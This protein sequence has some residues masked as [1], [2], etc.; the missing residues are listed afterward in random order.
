MQIS[1]KATAIL[2]HLYYLASYNQ[3][4]LN[5]KLIDLNPEFLNREA[6]SP[7]RFFSRQAKNTQRNE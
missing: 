2:I 6:L 7:L 1:W 3:D 5:D 4:K